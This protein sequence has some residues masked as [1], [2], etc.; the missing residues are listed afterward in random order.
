[1][2]WEGLE[3]LG[4]HPQKQ[5]L[6]APFQWGM[7]SALLQGP[8]GPLHHACCLLGSWGHVSFLIWRNGSASIPLIPH[9]GEFIQLSINI[10][11]S[12]QAL[13]EVDSRWNLLASASV[14]S[15]LLNAE[16]SASTVCR[17]EAGSRFSLKNLGY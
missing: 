17:A 15:M 11:S 8:P 10:I 5:K 14:P 9:Y 13:E 1:M 4:L 2:T 3:I 6:A 7:A 16:P 12:S